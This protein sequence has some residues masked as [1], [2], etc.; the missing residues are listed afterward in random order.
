MSARRAGKA[1]SSTIRD[2]LGWSIDYTYLDATFRET[3]TVASV[4]HPAADDGEIEVETGDRLPLTPEHLLKAGLRFAP[5]DDFT[6]G[7]DLQ[8]T[9]EQFVRGD[10]GN[11]A[12]E[13]EGYAVLNVRAEYRFGQNVRAFASIGNL[14]DEEYATFGVFGEPDEVLGDEFD[15]PLFMSPGAPRAVYFGLRLDF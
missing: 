10:E 12:A 1:S 4:N 14:L 6:F 7:A 3:F 15:E 5:T 11:S 2:R 8:W 9:S 13:L